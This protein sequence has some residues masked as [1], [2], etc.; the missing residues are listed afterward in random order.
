MTCSR[1][2]IPPAVAV[3]VAAELPPAPTARPHRAP[4]AREPIAPLAEPVEPSRALGFRL[5]PRDQRPLVI[6]AGL[7]STLVLLGA[8][9][10]FEQLLAFAAPVLVLVLPLLAGRFVGEDRIARVAGAF[11]G[12]PAGPPCCRPDGAAGAAAGHA[13]RRLIGPPWRSAHLRSRLSSKRSSG[14]VPAPSARSFEPRGFVLR[15]WAS[16]VVSVAVLGVAVPAALAHQGNPNFRSAVRALTPAQRGI[17]TQV[18][19]YDDS[20]ELQYRSGKTVVVE[21]YRGE[22]YVRIGADGTVAV[23]H[24]SPSYYLNDDRYADGVSVPADA[25]PKATPDWQT[26]DR[27]GRFA[28]HDH[29]IHWMAHTVPPQVKDDGKRTKIFDWK[30]PL[31]VGGR[32]AELTGTLTWVGKPGGGFPAAAGIALVGAALGGLLLVAVVRRRRAVPEAAAGAKE[33]W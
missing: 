1:R 23:N 7:A 12:A 9:A 27:T 26:V 19:N 4:D 20:I 8:L 32:P 6:S 13:R 10:G 33:A 3:L 14:R 24:R 25:T 5:V 31:D 30:V 2:P 18:V 16:A 17:D 28:W 22:P 21:G 29:R 15:L 11:G